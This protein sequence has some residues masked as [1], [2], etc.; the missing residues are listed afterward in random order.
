MDSGVRCHV[1]TP[2]RSPRALLLLQH[3][4][5]EYAE[6][7][8]AH[9]RG[10][11]PRLTALGFEVWAPDLRGHGG[12]P[13]V[14]GLTDVELAVRD[15]VTLRRALAER[16]TPILLFGHSL[17]GLVTAGSLAEEPGG[18]AGVVL[19]G[20][21]LPAARSMPVRAIIGLL[22]AVVPSAPAPGRRSPLSE[23][24]RDPHV[25]STFA[26]D[27]HCYQGGIP[28]LLAATALRV[29]AT[30]RKGLPGWTAPTLVVHGTAD[31][32]TDH[33]GSI[34]LVRNIAVSDKT[35]HLVDGGRHESL[36]DV[37]NDDTVDLVLDWLAAH[38]A[39]DDR[40]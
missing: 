37:P 25:G 11:V 18:V 19:T 4:F 12:S 1:W 5:G 28:L 32:Y 17:G 34:E 6:R 36:H 21:A 22:A 3:G 31:T 23:L 15:H 13:G 7:Y 39:L 26:N 10:I 35:L 29:A 38:A 33:H 8:V 9:H 30:V 20:P 40:P 14:R 27:P 16:S 2:D 24:A